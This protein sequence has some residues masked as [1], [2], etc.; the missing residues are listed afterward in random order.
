MITIFD[1]ATVA[2]GTPVGMNT[3]LYPRF[4][5]ATNQILPG[6]GVYPLT[7]D[8]LADYNQ[9]ELYY[10]ENALQNAK[11]L[12]IA[13]LEII[14]H[15]KQYAN[16]VYNSV[17]YDAGKVARANLTAMIISFNFSTKTEDVWLD[18]NNN[19]LTLSEAE[20]HG[21]FDVMQVSQQSA[22]MTEANK[23]SE[24]MAL[25]NLSDVETYNL[26]TGW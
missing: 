20:F 21:L 10:L 2:D 25:T 23:Y 22:Y 11:D 16:V 6:H 18:I 13:K 9:R 5:Q 3:N 4:D 19:Q 17:T 12:K 8:D 24:I 1:G 14:R 15:E 7:G 26:N